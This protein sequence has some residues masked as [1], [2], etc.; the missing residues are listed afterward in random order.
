MLDSARRAT[1]QAPNSGAAWRNLGL[2]LQEGGAFSEAFDAYGRALAL[3][4]HDHQVA[5]ALAIC[6]GQ[7]GL[8]DEA[9][10]LASH[11]VRAQP[12]DRIGQV[13]LV[14][15]LLGLD[16]VVEA[17]DRA[18]SAL[19]SSPEDAG[20]WQLA[21]K[22]ARASGGLSEAVQAFGQAHALDPNNPRI[23]Y[24]LAWTLADLGDLD[25]SLELTNQALGLNPDAETRAA[26]GFLKATVLLA[27]GNLADGWT[28]YGARHDL[29]LSSAAIYELDLA[30][31][32]GHVTLEGRR[33]LLMAEQGLGDEIAFMGMMD[34]ALKLVGP[35]GEIILCADKRLNGLIQRSWPNVTAIG[36]KTQQFTGRRHRWT[37]RPVEADLWTPLGDLLPMLRPDISAFNPPRGFLKP[38]PQRLAHWQGWLASLPGDSKIGMA[39]RS[40][41]MSDERG[42]NFAALSAW[43]PIL[44]RPRTS[45]VSLQYGDTASERAELLERFG[46]VVHQPPEL[47]LFN[48]LEGLA[49]LSAGLDLG[50]GGSNASTNLLG[51]VGTPL[52]LI[53]PPAPWPAL[54]QSAYPWYPGA[55]IHAAPSYGDWDSAMREA[56]KAISA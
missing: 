39:W 21:G 17:H 3:D 26:L 6:A 42:R 27:G 31:W 38:C 5:L 20:L 35:S 23:V 37:D 44:S 10:A 14:N 47:D 50:I 36:H 40:H 2:A 7:L 18:V 55:Q 4:P 22:T 53:A 51:A 46:V 52:H 30:R 41:K 33:L 48:D 43:G 9:Y 34:D 24:D 28:A 8:R 56:A 32:D 29:A 1:E 54:G 11:Y 12:A 13:T 19:S 45:F 49:A 25:S 15:A 16:R